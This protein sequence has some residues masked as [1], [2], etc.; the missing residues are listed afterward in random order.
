MPNSRAGLGVVRI[1]WIALG[2]SSTSSASMG[3]TNQ[4]QFVVECTYVSRIVED[5]FAQQQHF[6][7]DLC[8]VGGNVSYAFTPGILHLVNLPGNSHLPGERLLLQVRN[9]SVVDLED[10][11]HARRSLRIDQQTDHHAPMWHGSTDNAI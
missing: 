3:P 11:H 2:L 10:W 5:H 1:L 4:T 6:M 7:Y 9:A 8:S